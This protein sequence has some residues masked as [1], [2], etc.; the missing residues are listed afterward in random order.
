MNLVRPV[1]AQT[2][3][4][5]RLLARILLPAMTLALVPALPFRLTPDPNDG[6][7]AGKGAF[8]E[9]S[10][11]APDDTING[12][13]LTDR[14]LAQRIEQIAAGIP[15]HLLADHPRGARIRYLAQSFGAGDDAPIFHGVFRDPAAA[16]AFGCA[17]DE[18]LSNRCGIT[19]PAEGS[20]V[21]E[22]E[23]PGVHCEP[24]RL[25]LGAPAYEPDRC[26][27]E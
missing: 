3:L 16:L 27:A 13:Q 22:E 23:V 20:T 26:Q 2:P 4:A 15:S 10:Y 11:I 5:P 19:P 8:V 1:F 25:A 12:E 21:F 6:P 18:D 24:M 9:R 14:T 7:R 17:L